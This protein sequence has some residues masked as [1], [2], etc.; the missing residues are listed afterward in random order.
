MF[1][2][3]L[4]YFEGS[5]RLRTQIDQ[6]VCCVF[7]SEKLSGPIFTKMAQKLAFE[8]T[9]RYPNLDLITKILLY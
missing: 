4:A 2:Q 1:F 7:Y 9:E 5:D 6:H 3:I 8:S